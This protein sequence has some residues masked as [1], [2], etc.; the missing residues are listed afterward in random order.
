M[1]VNLRGYWYL[2]V[3]A[4]RLM[5]QRGGG[6]IVNIA[7]IAAWHPDRM[8]S[9]YSTL[10]TALIGMSRSFALECGDD[11][12]R[13]NTILP[14]V[15]RTRLA[16]A[17]TDEQ[18]QQILSRTPVGR[19]GEPEDIGHAV[20][21]LCSAAGAYISGASLPVDGGTSIGLI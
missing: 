6:S 7:S 20:L 13:A 19:L 8:L 16:D 2:S 5:R 11:N 21:F 3:E 14:G 12:I 10:K 15:I 1:D 18:K 9:L 4:V 17:Y